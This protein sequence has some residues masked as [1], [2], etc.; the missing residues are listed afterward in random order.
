MLHVVQ[1]YKHRRGGRQGL[2][3]PEKSR[4]HCPF[5]EH[6][7]VPVS[8]QSDQAKGPGQRRGQGGNNP[9]VYRAHKVRQADPR[10]P[11]FGRGGSRN[12]HVAA[13]GLSPAHSPF[14]NR[15]LAD[16]RLTGQPDRARR[17]RVQRRSDGAALTATARWD[18]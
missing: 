14:P 4:A 8:L 12:Q 11:G 16:P 7:V 3:H 17:P 15:G 1:G 18:L 2:E 5:V 13:L 10:Q 6:L 9:L